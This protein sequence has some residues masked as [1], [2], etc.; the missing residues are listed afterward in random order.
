MLHWA[1]KVHSANTQLEFNF[2]KDTCIFTN[3]TKSLGPVW[4]GGKSQEFW[5]KQFRR[6]GNERCRLEQRK[7]PYRSRGKETAC[8]Q[9]AGMRKSTPTQGNGGNTAS[10]VSFLWFSFPAIQ[11]IQ[12]FHSYNFQSCS[13]PLFTFLYSCVIYHSSVLHSFVPNGALEPNGAEEGSPCRDTEAYGVGTHP[14]G[15]MTWR[16]YILRAV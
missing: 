6:K 13:F 5:R 4:I 16:K 8:T 3:L 11:T 7:L 9:N 14:G 10:D 15:S 12:M 2:N 1:S